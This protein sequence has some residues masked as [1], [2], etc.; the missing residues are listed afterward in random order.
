MMRSSLL[1]LACLTLVLMTAGEADAREPEWSY[2]T[3]YDVYAV[4]ISADGEYIT[5]GSSDGRVYLFD[6]DTGTQLWNYTTGSTGV[7]SVAISADGE[8]IA[9][10]TS[11][12]KVYLFH[13]DSSTPLWNYTTGDEVHSASISADG[14]YIVAG[15]GTWPDEGHVP[16]PCRSAQFPIIT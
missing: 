3:G 16:Y 11:E 9:T 12:G 15:S 7:R 6:R 4:D 13:K 2:D 10:G 5:A 8:Y 1:L 14:K